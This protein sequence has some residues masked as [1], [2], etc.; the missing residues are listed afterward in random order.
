MKAIATIQAL[1]RIPVGG[2][3]VALP[4]LAG[5]WIGKD[6]GRRGPQVI[7]RAVGARDLA[8]GGGTLVALLTGKPAKAWH[9]AALVSDGV[10]FAATLAA[11]DKLPDRGATMV[12][13]AAGTACAVSVAY[14]LF[15]ERDSGEELEPPS[16]SASAETSA[17]FSNRSQASATFPSGSST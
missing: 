5:S 4:Q 13:A 10:D 1:V 11:R 8:L 17:P 6:A 2:A 7:I 9:A 12:L 14:L 16:P 15:G 3:L